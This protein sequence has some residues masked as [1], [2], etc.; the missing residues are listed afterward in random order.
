MKKILSLL[1]AVF[2]LSAYDGTI[3]Y[4]STTDYKGI[5]E[6][7]HTYTIENKSDPSWSLLL[8]TMGIKAHHTPSD[9]ELWLYVDSFMP[10]SPQ[11]LTN[12]RIRDIKFDIDV[13][14]VAQKG[15]SNWSK[16]VNRMKIQFTGKNYNEQKRV[17]GSNILKDSASFKIGEIVNVGTLQFLAPYPCKDVDQM[18]MTISN[19]IVK[20][21]PLPPLEILFKLK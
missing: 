18:K 11:C 10:N 16:M 1:V 15:D 4:A 7:V 12:K 2:M 5:T 13:Y 9:T 17:Y 19:I 8:D 20:G 6:P 21:R 3:D 14:K